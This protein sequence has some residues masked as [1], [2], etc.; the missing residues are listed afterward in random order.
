MTKSTKSGIQAKPIDE[1]TGEVRKPKLTK[2]ETEELEKCE[3]VIRK[4]WATFLE[5]GEALARIR[6]QKLYLGKYDNFNE[7][8]RKELGISRTYAYNLIGS[9]EVNHQLSSIEDFSV[10][11]TTESQL[12][13]LIPVPEAKRLE[14][15]KTALVL[16]DGKPITAKIIRKAAVKFK[17]RIKGRTKVRKSIQAKSIYLEPVFKL[18]AG[19]EKAAEGNQAILIELSALR[20][21]LEKLSE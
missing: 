15:W 8:W 21:G 2:E 4:G 14:A 18:L 19:A 11:P 16:A 17:P 20:K 1:V 9:A 12:R 6:D 5:V 7:Y 3:L 13:E 10:R